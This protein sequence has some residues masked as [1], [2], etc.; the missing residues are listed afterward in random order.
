M[1]PTERMVVALAELYFDRKVTLLAIRCITNLAMEALLRGEFIEPLILN[2]AA[3]VGL[4]ELE[5]I[6]EQI[7]LTEQALGLL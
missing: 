4:E 6:K 2:G 3:R 5:G 1:T 7:T